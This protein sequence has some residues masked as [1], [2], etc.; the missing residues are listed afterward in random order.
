MSHYQFNCWKLSD[1]TGLQTRLAAVGAD[2]DTPGNTV[3]ISLSG[4]ASCFTCEV[5]ADIAN[6][7]QSEGI[8]EN[9]VALSRDLTVDG[10]LLPAGSQVLPEFVLRSDITANA[11][12]IIGRIIGKTGNAKAGMALVFSSSGMTPGQVLN[13]TGLEASVLNGPALNGP[14]QNC[15]SRGTLIET[16]YGATPIEQLEDGDEVLTHT[17]CVQ[18]ISWIG[19]RRLSGLELVLNPGL[20]PVRIMAGALT[21]GR[22]GQDLIVSQNHRLL[23]DDWRAPFLYGEEEILAPAKS[24]LNNRNVFVDCPVSGIDYYHLLMDGHNLICAN[25]LWAETML[26]DE[27]TLSMLKPAQRDLVIHQLQQDK[28]GVQHRYR[29]V[30]PALPHHSVDR[31]AA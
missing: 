27:T 8:P 30:L 16:P 25:G 13:L 29:S 10:V 22:P 31:V 1:F 9:A 5:G 7:I 6:N 19:S 14:G 21:G 23:V 28:N 15:F 24:L 12:F 18:L 4:N 11:T 26:P 2:G 20:R 17:G 3:E